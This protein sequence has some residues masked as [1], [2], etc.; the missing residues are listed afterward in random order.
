MAPVLK[1][2]GTPQGHARDQRP[3]RAGS[4]AGAKSGTSACACATW[5]P[6]AVDVQVLSPTVFTFFYDQEPALAL[7]CAAIQNE[8]IAAVVERH[9]DRFIGLGSVP[10]QAPEQAADELRRGDDAAWPARRHD[11]HQCQRPQSR[12]SCAGA[13]L[14][15]GGRTR[16]LHLHPSA[17]RRRRRTACVLLHEELCLAAVRHDDRRGHV[18]CSAA[19]WSAIRS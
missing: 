1:G 11:R 3:G 15:G 7:A 10:L 6:T 4:D 12:R 18:W 5:M 19:S 9:P 2:R 17:R 13:V 16:R 14:G 8:E